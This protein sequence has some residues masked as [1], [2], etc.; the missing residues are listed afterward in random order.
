M[1]ASQVRRQQDKLAP[2]ED[3]SKWAGGWVLLRDGYVV[4]D[5]PDPAALRNSPDARD[6]DVLVPVPDLGETTSGY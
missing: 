5:G 4:S 3:L 6:E 2:K 1:S